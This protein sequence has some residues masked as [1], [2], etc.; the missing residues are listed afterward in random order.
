MI[1]IICYLANKFKRKIRYWLDLLIVKNE[2]NDDN[3]RFVYAFLT[4]AESVMKS[5]N[6]YCVHD[7]NSGGCV[8][9][10]VH[11]K[12]ETFKVQQRTIFNLRNFP[13]KQQTYA[14]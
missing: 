4:R 13:I 12:G 1:S 7:A 10:D 2:R 3:T 5:G 8:Y 6:I 14:N 11:N 9:I